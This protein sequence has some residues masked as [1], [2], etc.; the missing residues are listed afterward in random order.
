[1]WPRVR[2]V[3]GRVA[4]RGPCA[5]ETRGAAWVPTAPARP[6]SQCGGWGLHRRRGA[7][8]SAFG[9]AA[10]KSRQPRTWIARGPALG[11]VYMSRDPRSFFPPAL[12]SRRTSASARPVPCRPPERAGGAARSSN[13]ILSRAWRIRSGRPGPQPR[14]GQCSRRN[15]S[16]V[17]QVWRR[18]VRQSASFLG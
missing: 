10:E 8:S 17:A 6:R 15:N 7:H 11:M 3:G 1:M 5:A 13:P 2:G 12:T 16:W 9:R 4:F 14:S 18:S